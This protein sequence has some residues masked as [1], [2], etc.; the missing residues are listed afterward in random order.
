M[1][2]RGGGNNS[3]SSSSSNSS[4]GS[5][6]NGGGVGE[7]NSNNNTTSSRCAC[8]RSLQ[9]MGVHV[10]PTTGGQFQLRVAATDSIEFL[11]RLV[12]KRLRV[13]KERICLLYRDRVV[14][15]AGTVIGFS[16]MV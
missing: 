1:M 8:G 10:T 4:S 16:V 7:E 3:S 13:P 15:M 11:R 14:D 9:M 2:E 12:S 5:S 6:N